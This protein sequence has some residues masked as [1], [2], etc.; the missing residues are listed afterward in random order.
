MKAR[1]L[2]LATTLAASGVLPGCLFVGVDGGVIAFEAYDLSDQYAPTRE[3]VL[4]TRD[5]PKEMLSP[6][7]DAVLVL[8]YEP[9]TM[10][11]D[12]KRRI[13]NTYK[14]GTEGR[15]LRYP[16]HLFTVA[17]F[18]ERNV[19]TAAAV[20]MAVL[21]FA[22]GR[23]PVAFSEEDS[24]HHYAGNFNR[25]AF[26]ERPEDELPDYRTPKG[27]RGLA[28]IIFAK[29]QRQWEELELKQD[30]GRLVWDAS[31]NQWRWTREQESPVSAGD[32][33]DAIMKGD[34]SM[35]VRI[36]QLLKTSGDRLIRSIL[37]CDELQNMDR[38]MVLRQ[39]LAV[40]SENPGE[41]LPQIE[42]KIQS[43]IAE[44]ET[45]R[46]RGAPR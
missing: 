20:S 32:T 21:A 2:M 1:W 11:E 14:L 33:P 34:E 30:L 42:S 41:K 5:P 19:H 23:P 8:Y 25:K 29:N 24:W 7:T 45:E 39:L 4:A 46:V 27:T 35:V 36:H 17:I 9:I 40:L 10:K 16:P 15:R 13:I 26:M 28:R 22:A 44:L 43:T 38:L 18:G 31:A 3:R 12:P 37:R 6:L